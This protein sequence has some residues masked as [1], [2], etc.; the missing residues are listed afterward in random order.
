[1]ELALNEAGVRM[2]G[3]DVH[4]SDDWGGVEIYV[5]LSPDELNASI[6]SGD[7]FASKPLVKAFTK[8][9][10]PFAA[11]S[12]INCAECRKDIPIVLIGAVQK[13][14][15]AMPYSPAGTR[16]WTLSPLKK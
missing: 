2:H 8:A 10:I 3:E 12:F 16:S 13:E 4:F 9:E 15:L 7:V 14:L 5:P 6:G 11:T 1:M